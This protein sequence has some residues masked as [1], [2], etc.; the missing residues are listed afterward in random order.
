MHYKSLRD[1]DG[2]FTTTEKKIHTIRVTENE[3]KFIL[4]LR[5]NEGKERCY[6]C[7]REHNLIEDKLD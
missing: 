3:K 6:F 1:S 2:K 5:K 4:N 7:K